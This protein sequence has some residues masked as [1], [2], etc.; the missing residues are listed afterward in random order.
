MSF[1]AP[2]FWRRK[3]LNGHRRALSLTRLL[4][5]GPRRC[6]GVAGGRAQGRF[7]NRSRIQEQVANS[8]RGE[9]ATCS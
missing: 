5:G 3:S 4:R 8:P 1:L 7:K 2:G 6:V 9:F